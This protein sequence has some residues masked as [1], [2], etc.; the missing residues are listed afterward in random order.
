MQPACMST[1][2]ADGTAAFAACERLCMPRRQ[3]LRCPI[4]LDVR[5]QRASRG[6]ACAGIPCEIT[7][8]HHVTMI[9]DD[10]IL[11]VVVLVVMQ[12]GVSRA[13]GLHW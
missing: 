10:L 2:A 13:G 3:L 8:H 4:P 1:S 6:E 9:R 7:K 12:Y 11:Y 5:T